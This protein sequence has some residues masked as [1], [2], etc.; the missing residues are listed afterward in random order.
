MTYTT[1]EQL[2]LVMSVEQLAEVLDIGKIMRMSL[3]AAVQYRV[4]VSVIVSESRRNL[5]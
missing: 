5:L 2:P 1:F 3:F 4:F